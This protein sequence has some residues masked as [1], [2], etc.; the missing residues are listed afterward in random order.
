MFIHTHDARPRSNN[1]RRKSI[2]VAAVATVTAA[3]A[4][5]ITP[6]AAVFRHYRPPPIPN[7]STRHVVDDGT[8]GTVLPL[9][10]R[11]SHLRSHSNGWILNVVW[12]PVQ[13]IRMAGIVS[14]DRVEL[15][16]QAMGLAHV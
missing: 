12:R 3:V 15:C 10:N 6:S 4:A 13:E 2:I 9:A 14:V 16:E 11:C 8:L 7:R 1:L 5:V